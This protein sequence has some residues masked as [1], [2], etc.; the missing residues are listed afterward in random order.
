ML[1]GRHHFLL[2]R[3]H[4]LTGILFG[5]YLLVH[6][7]VNAS[8]VQGGG[9]TGIYQKQVD[10]IHDLPLLVGIEWACIFL[11]LLYHA[12]YGIWITLTGQPNV[13]S[14]PFGKNWFY[15]MQRIS[16]IVLIAFIGFHVLSLKFGLFGSA[17]TFDPEHAIASMREHLRTSAFLAF[18]VYPI[19]VLAACFHLSNGFWAA[20]VT[21][22]LTVSAAGQRRWGAV[23]AVLFALTMAAGLTAVLAARY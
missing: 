18:V 13:N 19:G 14:Y 21:W 17:L 8:I 4:S 6:L 9:L 7:T 11:P 16:A 12:L 10:K 15:L 22:G 5:G 2:R 20:G 23:C 1:G 3:L